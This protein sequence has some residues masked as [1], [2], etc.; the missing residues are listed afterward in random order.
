MDSAEQWKPEGYQR[1]AVRWLLEHGGAGLLLDPGLGK[2]SISL[3]AFKILKRERIAD[4]MLV[5]A[6]R[7]PCTLV[8]PPERD[9]WKDFS[10]LSMAVLR[11]SDRER[12]LRQKHDIYVINPE[13]L[14]WLVQHPL[15]RKRFHGAVLCVDESS[16]YRH[17]KT[18]RFKILKPVLPL[19]RRRWILTGSPAPKNL[20]DLFGQIYILDLGRALGG[21]ITY[22][23]YEHFDK[24]GYGGYSYKL[25]PGHDKK[26]YA[27]IKPL[28]LRMSAE[29]YLKLPPISGMIGMKRSKPLITWVDLPDKARRHYDQMEE[30]FVAQLARGE[31]R[32]SNAGVASMKCR[33]I[34]SGGL[35]YDD[36]KKLRKGRDWQELHDAKTEAVVDLLEELQGQPALVA[37][38]FNH[39][40]ERLRKVL[41]K[42][43]PHVGG[44]LTDKRATIIERA[45]NN[46]DLPYL[47]V[48][49]SSAAWGLNLQRGGRAVIWHT[50]TWNWEYYYQL[51]KRIW[52]RGQTQRVFVHH[53]LARDTMELAMLY[54][55]RKKAMT[56]KALLDALRVHYASLKSLDV[57]R[58]RG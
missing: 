44:G 19:F 51:V 50:L 32:A 13:G 58:I 7:R 40:L 46:G 36:R 12:R 5:I 29:E 53:V 48:N 37:Y 49:P 43:T 34:A 22:Y 18:Q 55:L 27:K 4:V 45:W 31:V 17:T 33:Q 3:A 54:A 52:R 14:P 23:R 30:L 15:F 21:F 25:K 24:T 39:D 26:I 6:P 56:E 20:M 11:G 35:Y 57:R 47:L 8:W 16:K 1:R 28:V 10:T 9:K 41:G 2:T 38:E 42:D